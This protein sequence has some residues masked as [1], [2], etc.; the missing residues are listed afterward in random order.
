MS[1][2]LEEG[3][4][5]RDPSP[6]HESDVGR[7]PSDKT[8]I[9]PL[10]TV[11]LNKSLPPFSVVFR[12]LGLHEKVVQ[13]FTPQTT[14]Q[15]TPTPTPTTTPQSVPLFSSPIIPSI[16]MVMDSIVRDQDGQLN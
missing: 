7:I 10:P 15:T 13:I 3:K 5:Q 1:P 16:V 12:S 9:S 8:I 14:S 2:E 11:P 4:E 6:P